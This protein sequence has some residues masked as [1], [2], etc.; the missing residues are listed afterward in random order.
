MKKGIKYPLCILLGFFTIIILTQASRFIFTS[1]KALQTPEGLGG[2][3]GY[4]LFLTLNF[5]LWKILI[6]PKVLST[7]D[8]T[9]TRK[10]LHQ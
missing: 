7:I 2:L 1:G 5:Y 9:N 8:K 4:F 6:K 3:L 10:E